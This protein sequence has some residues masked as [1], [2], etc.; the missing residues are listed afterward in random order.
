[1]Q[2]KVCWFPHLKNKIDISIHPAGG[3]QKTERLERGG[4]CGLLKLRQME[5]KEYTAHERGSFFGWFVELIVPVQ[6]IFVLPWLL[7]KNTFFLTVTLFHFICLHCPASWAGSR[8]ASHVS[9]DVSLNKEHWGW[10]GGGSQESP[11]EARGHK[12]QVR[13]KITDL[14]YSTRDSDRG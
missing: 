1:M 13:S 8:A 4:P 5:T 7:V 2:W 6:K 3:W 10:G 14:I 9:Y 12:V 11:W